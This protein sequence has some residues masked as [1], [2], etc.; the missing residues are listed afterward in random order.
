MTFE[1]CRAKVGDTQLE[2]DE[3]FIGLAMGFPATGQRWS[4]NCKVEEVPWTL[5]FQLR[6][7]TSCDKGLTVT[8]LKQC[9]HDLLMIIK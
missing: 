1:G 4:R 5:L 2:I 8:M 3:W 6:K 9:W 7:I